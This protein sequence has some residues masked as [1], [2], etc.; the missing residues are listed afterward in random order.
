MLPA[1]AMPSRTVM[2]LRTRSA[3]RAVMMALSGFVSLKLKASIL[4]KRM[5]DVNGVN[6]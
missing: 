3:V 4:G 2:A 5:R 6:V 1:A